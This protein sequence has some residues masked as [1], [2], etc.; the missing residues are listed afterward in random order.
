MLHRH[1]TLL[2]TT[3][4]LQHEASWNAL[5]SS[6]IH[7]RSHS[8]RGTEGTAGALGAH[9]PLEDYWVTQNSVK[10]HQNTPLSVKKSESFLRKRLPL[11]KPFPHVEGTHTI[12]LS[13][14]ITTRS[15]LCHWQHMTIR[16][17]SVIF[18]NIH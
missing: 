6:N 16:L 11:P 13:A 18:S 14:P 17:A 5:I 4:N 8:R 9:A 2:R 1:C 7:W 3:E 10:M 12:P 15:Q